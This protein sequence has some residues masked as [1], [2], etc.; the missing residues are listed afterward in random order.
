MKWICL[1]YLGKNEIEE[2]H[3]AKCI[4]SQKCGVTINWWVRSLGD[5]IY[6]VKSE[7]GKIKIFRKSA[8]LL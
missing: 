6:M 8:R 7:A 3:K 4:I 1:A 5:Y 2:T